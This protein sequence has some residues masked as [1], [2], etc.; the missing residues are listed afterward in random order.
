MKDTFELCTEGRQLKEQYEAALYLWRKCVVP[1][2]TR[3]EDEVSAQDALRLRN[4]ALVKR[5][6]AAN[7]MYVHRT[8]CAFCN[9]QR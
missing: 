5:N 4:E 1:M 9:H 6:A 8:R 7:C 3:P 2:Q